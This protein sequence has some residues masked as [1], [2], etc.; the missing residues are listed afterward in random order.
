MD[1]IENTKGLIITFTG[2]GK[3]K[4]TAALGMALRALG[5]GMKVTILQFIKGGW[6]YGE[7]MMAEKLGPDFSIKQM[8]L[9]F[10]RNLTEEQKKQH[11]QVAIEALE[12]AVQ[13]ITSD[14]YQ[15]VILDEVF[16]G[17]KYGFFTVSDLVK[18]LQKK[19]PN[20]HLVL[21]GRDAPEEIT[22][23]SDLVT[24]MKEIKHPY[25]KGIIAQ[26]GVEY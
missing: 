9:G 7:L 25:K 11:K 15:M 23:L 16:Y 12:F 22:G 19:P 17:I 5:Q 18:L 20:L 26:K 13:I 14:K 8:G 10:V 2:N 1:S 3:G 21:T 6:E 4:T 24:E